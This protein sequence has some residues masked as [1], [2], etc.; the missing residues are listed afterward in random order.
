MS[1]NQKLLIESESEIK[2]KLKR[3]TLKAWADADFRQALKDDAIGALKS[4][5][6]DFG[7]HIKPVFHVEQ[8]NERHF[9]IPPSP[10]ASFSK[11]IEFHL[12]RLA[13]LHVEVTSTVSWSGVQHPTE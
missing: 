12:N 4:E 13:T 2:T 10:A 11:D 7:Q 8:G 1:E 9:V 6:I 3:I 5:G